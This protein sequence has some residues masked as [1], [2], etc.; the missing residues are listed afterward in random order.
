MDKRRVE[1]LIAAA[2]EHGV[3][4]RWRG[5]DLHIIGPDALN[6]LTCMLDQAREDGVDISD[7]DPPCYWRPRQGAAASSAAP[8]DE[9]E[10]GEIVA[11]SELAALTAGAPAAGAPAAPEPPLMPSRTK[12]RTEVRIYKDHPPN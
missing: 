9:D 12:A 10:V 6:W 4:I 8:D 7:V 2:T 3:T 1:E 11:P 5:D